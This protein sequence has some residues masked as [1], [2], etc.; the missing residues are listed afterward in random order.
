MRAVIAS[1]VHLGYELSERDKFLSF[2]DTVPSMTPDYFIIAGDLFEFW[3][4]DMTACL[5]EN[6]DILN[7]LKELST[8]MEVFLV[9]GNHDQHVF[10]TYSAEDSYVEP[11]RFYQSIN[12]QSD[13]SD[14][15]YTVSHGHQYDTACRYQRVN[16]YLCYST[17]RLGG[18]MDRVSRF[19]PQQATLFRPLKASLAPSEPF[20]LPFGLKLVNYVAE[21]GF[22]SKNPSVVRTIRLR[23]L[24]DKHANEYLIYGHTHTPF[25]DNVQ[26]FA[27][28]GCWVKGVC[29]YLTVVDDNVWL[30]HYV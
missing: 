3:R 27:D 10:K 21:P 26:E 7:K 8:Q 28:A 19:I 17:D 16:N 23:A 25:V 12:L 9:Y 4:R 5:L 30:E 2:L 22:I 13:T 14:R 18:Y 11:F 20:M 6:V 24:G 15:Y 1:D 29:T